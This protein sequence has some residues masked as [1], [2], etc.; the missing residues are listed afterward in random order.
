MAQ[1]TSLRVQVIAVGLCKFPLYILVYNGR[2]VRAV[3]YGI[4]SFGLEPPR[5]GTEGYPGV[6]TN[7]AYYMDWILDTMTD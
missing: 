7:V 5:C 1:I 4:V 6:Y 3:Q 2:A